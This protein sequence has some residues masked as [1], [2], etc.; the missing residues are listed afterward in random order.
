MSKPYSHLIAP[1]IDIQTLTP[2]QKKALQDL[3]SGN[4]GTTNQRGGIHR[5]LSNLVKETG[6]KDI[7][8]K[9]MFDA[10]DSSESIKNVKRNL[11]ALNTNELR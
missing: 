11:L 8:S 3:L 6:A 4:I 1:R 7:T 10:L 9:A 2:A 5:I